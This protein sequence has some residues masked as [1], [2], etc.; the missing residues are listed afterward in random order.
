MD[1]LAPG[2]L[3]ATPTIRDDQFAGTVVLLAAHGEDG[4]LGF[5]LNRTMDTPLARVA[6][7]LDIACIDRLAR[8]LVRSGGP[9]A[10]ERGWVL[11]RRAAAD[12]ASIEIRDDLHVSSAL[13]TLERL[14]GEE[15]GGDIRFFVGYAGWGPK[16]LESEIQ[17]G[18]WLPI[19]LEEDLI[20]D[21]PEDS[22]WDEAVRRTGLVPGQF[23]MHA[24][25]SD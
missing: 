15:S 16:Q 10:Q 5:V 20:F 23:A 1:T 4:S 2:L 25:V 21:T 8:T 7:Q 14:L 9:V 24:P 22:L 3:I 17:Q 18:A 12:D 19:G 11:F 6:R 13:H